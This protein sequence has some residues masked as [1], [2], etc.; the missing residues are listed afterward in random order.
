MKH[1]NSTLALAIA[2][3]ATLLSAAPADAAVR[4]NLQ[5]SAACKAA[6]GPG[7]DVFYFDTLYAQNTS[8]S[9]QYLTCGV[10]EFNPGTNRAADRVEVLVRNPTASSM[11]FTCV[12]Q[13][14]YS[15]GGVNNAVANVT[16]AAN[17]TGVFDFSAS[18]TPALPARTSQY[19]PYTLSC[20]VP[21][22]GRIDT[23]TVQYPETF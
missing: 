18:T 21:A 20:A 5:A 12:L 6:A 22:Q 13:A 14:G 9:L 15:V 11:T 4:M 19:A 23:V 8:G 3:L 1:L 7:A 10:P 2:G 17:S 16:V